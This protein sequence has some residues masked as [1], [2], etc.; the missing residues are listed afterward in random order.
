[1]SSNNGRLRARPVAPHEHQSVDAG[2]VPPRHR[3]RAP[4]FIGLPPG[5]TSAVEQILDREGVA[6]FPSLNLVPSELTWAVGQRARRPHKSAAATSEQP[7]TMPTPRNPTRSRK[8]DGS[9][10]PARPPWSKR[11]LSSLRNRRNVPDIGTPER[12]PLFP[13]PDAIRPRGRTS[14]RHTGRSSS[15]PC[16]DPVHAATI[17]LVN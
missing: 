16:H 12:Q 1:M 6:A 14:R 2:C 11:G 9:S 17:D 7:S 3:S 10:F 15:P 5:S 8:R 4:R 13:T